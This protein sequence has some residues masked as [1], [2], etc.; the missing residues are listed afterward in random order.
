MDVKFAFLNG[1]L[2]EKVYVSQ[3][4]GFEVKGKEH[5]VYRLYKAL[6]GL[7]QTPRVWN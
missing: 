1:P 7:K 5:M 4:P 6:Y 3:S 2:D